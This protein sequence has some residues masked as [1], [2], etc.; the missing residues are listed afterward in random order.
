MP[1]RPLPRLA[2]LTSLYPAVSHTFIQREIA[3]L[4]ALGFAVETCS[5]RRPDPTHLNGPE[6]REAEA[7][8]F[9]ILDAAR[10]PTILPRALL[11]TLARPSRALQ[12]LAL[13]WRTA[14]PG[15]RGGLKQLAYLA[16]AMILARHLVARNIDHLHNHFATASAN[17]AMLASKI[18]G[19]PFSYTLHGPSDLCEPDTWQLREKTARAD[20][21]ACI[22]HFARSQAMLFCAPD[23]WQKLRIVHCGVFPDLYAHPALASRTGMHLIFV[24]RLAPVKGLRV[25]FEAFRKSWA[26]HPD[27][28]L[29]LVGDG[30]DRAHL[31]KLAKPFGDVVRFAGYMSQDQVAAT[32]QSADAFVL[33]SFAEGLPVVLMEAL[34]S[35]RPVIATQVAGVAELVEDG[36]NGFLV[37]PGDAES[38]AGRISALADDPALRTRM[39]AAGRAKVE[40]EF[41]AHREAA[42]IAALFVGEG[43]HNPR[44]EPLK[45]A[46]EMS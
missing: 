37:P 39:G 10:R 46:R 34:A 35:E 18:S 26:A 42:R 40:A 36:A 44:P 1:R 19:I 12:T 7:D 4:R 6:E 17:V 30:E 38:L 16:E 23:Q 22:S 2:Y 25:L 13:A 45:S 32:L 20:F 27:L 33:P 29:T 14:P 15:I 41:D 43:G 21:V 24:G 31:E 9:Y 11:F 5:V 28:R 3:G 8:S